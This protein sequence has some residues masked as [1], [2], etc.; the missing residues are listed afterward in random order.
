MTK[1]EVN[2][3]E[4]KVTNDPDVTLYAKSLGSSIAIAVV[5]MNK[6]CVGLLVSPF[7]KQSLIEPEIQEDDDKFY[8]LDVGLKSMFKEIL[9]FGCKKEQLKIYLVGG[10]QFLEAPKILSIGTLL[11]QAV[12]KLLQKNGLTIFGEAV[13]GPINRSITFNIAGDLVVKSA[14][15]QEVA[16]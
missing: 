12:K 5:D 6:K 15:S 13:G 10:A 3:G 14:F 7:L 16:L 11:Y 1:L 8:A 4:W 9:S 2:K